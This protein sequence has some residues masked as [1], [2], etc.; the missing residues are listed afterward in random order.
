MVEDRVPNGGYIPS[1]SGA[2]DDF[3]VIYLLHDLMIHSQI[4]QFSHDYAKKKFPSGYPSTPRTSDPD[5]Q[6]MFAMTQKDRCLRSVPPPHAP[7]MY[8][9]W[10]SQPGRN[11]TV[12]YPLLALTFGPYLNSAQG[13][14]NKA[15][16]TK[17]RRLVAHAMPSLL[18]TN[19]TSAPITRRYGVESDDLL[20]TVNR[21][22]AAPLTY[23]TSP[24]AAR[25]DAPLRGP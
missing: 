8:N 10:L 23:R 14:G 12:S 4:R 24:L 9:P 19:E 6:A 20:W 18:Y 11:L 7:T 15:R 2:S 16:E 1:C 21:G 3:C 13:T 22:N 5:F 17:P 25:A